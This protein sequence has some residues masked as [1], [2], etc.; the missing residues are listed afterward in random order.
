[1]F[2]S[3]PELNAIDTFFVDLEIDGDGI[4]GSYSINK[5]E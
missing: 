5:K 2:E 4:P 1:M 3:I